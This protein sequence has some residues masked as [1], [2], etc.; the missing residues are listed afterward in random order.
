MLRVNPSIESCVGQS[1]S[2]TALLGEAPLVAAPAASF[3]QWQARR[4][5]R[6]IVCHDTYKY[7]ACR[8][9]IERLATSAMTRQ[10]SAEPYCGTSAR[11]LGL[12]CVLLFSQ[13]WD[14]SQGVSYALQG[15]CELRNSAAVTR[16][17]WPTR[18]NAPL[19]SRS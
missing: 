19:R 8:R 1:Q 2:R 18:N 4:M 9:T 13:T 7:A 15:T 5:R 12:G 16:S 17:W 11:Y 6:L 14:R 3:G 10:N